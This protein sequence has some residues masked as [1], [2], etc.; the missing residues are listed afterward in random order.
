MNRFTFIAMF[1]HLALIGAIAQDA[2]V[3]NQVIG[4][5]GRSGI[6][7]GRI[8]SYTVGEVVIQT[9]QSANRFLTQGFHQPEQGRLVSVGSPDLTDWDILVFPN[10]V[11]DV[12]NI[13]FAAEKGAALTATVFD[14]VGRMVLF[15]H[16]V[17]D[18]YG[19]ALDCR[20]WQPGIYFLVLTDP[21]SRASA[22]TRIIRL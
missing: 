5:T 7:Q 6:H 4:A 11:T 20:N 17:L 16:P 9:G 10:P 12:L 2:S 15:D 3:F 14:A 22:T 18:P 13:R 1:W 21:L 19:S 8:F